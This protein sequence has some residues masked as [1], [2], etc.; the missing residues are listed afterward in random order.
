[1]T[2]S[3][4][5]F[6]AAQARAEQ[7]NDGAELLV[8]VHRFL[9]D[10]PSSDPDRAM[11]RYGILGGRWQAMGGGSVVL[12]GGDLGEVR[13]GVALAGFVELVNFTQEEPVP[14]ESFRANIGLDTLFEAPRLTR[15][16]LP[17]GGRLYL[18]LGWFH[19]SDHAANLDGYKR[20]FL[21]NVASYPDF[22]NGN[23]SSYE[24]V[25]LRV[26]WQ[27]EHLCGRLTTLVGL[28]GRFFL[29]SINPGSLREM[30]GSFSAETRLRLRAT[31]KLSPFVASSFELVWNDFVAA[32]HGFRGG[33]DAEPLR[34]R[35]LSAGLDIRSAG[36]AVAIPELVFSSSHGRGVDFPKFYGSEL[37]FRIGFLL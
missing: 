8:S 19:E 1:M 27:Q 29:P 16:I 9:R 2:G 13:A 31:D 28:G 25:K 10:E 32:Q 3:A 24:Y 4:L 26:A 30:Q 21:T 18:T 33:L 36:G 17:A 11:L 6:G 34:Y 22:D 37:G 20:D 14:W 15:A 35:T 7:P 5:T 23:F 12:A